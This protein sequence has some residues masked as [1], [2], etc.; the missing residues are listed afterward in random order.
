MNARNQTAWFAT[1]AALAIAL[2]IGFYALAFGVASVLF[3]IPYAEWRYL[4]RIDIRLA[5]G[6]IASGIALLVSVVPRKDHFVPPGPRLEERDHPKLFAVLRDVASATGQPMPLDVYLLNEVNAFVAARGGRMGIGSIRVMGVGLPLIQVLTVDGLRAVI[7]HEFGHFWAGDLKLGPWIH[8]THCAIAQTI[9]N[10]GDA[11]LGKPFV[12]YNQLFLR[13]TMAVSRRQEFV[14]DEISARVT[15]SN[16]AAAALQRIAVTAPA[17]TAYLQEEVVPALSSGVLPPLAS[18]FDQ[19]LSSPRIN[20]AMTRFAAEGIHWQG[21]AFDTHPAL[22]RRLEALAAVEMPHLRLQETAPASTLI[23]DPEQLATA[24]L[25]F[26]AGD[27]AVARLKPIG[28]SDVGEAVYAAGWRA[29]RQQFAAS[30]APFTI[31]SLPVGD[32]E[33]VEAGRRL[34]LPGKGRLVDRDDAYRRAI[35]VLVAA[36]GVYLMDRGWILQTSIGHPVLLVR[37]SEFIEPAAVV[38][39]LS[40]NTVDPA[41]WKARCTALGLAGCSLA[42][43][44][45]EHHTSV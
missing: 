8:K 31:D 21:H 34:V 33:T 6:C 18:G 4:E 15:S 25:S 23:N 16:V 43:E 35:E 9:A 3:W 27:E 38:V 28:W 22:D 44:A 11:W 10:L 14:A 39:G 24:L 40:Q 2:M 45:A 29:T 19:Y 42:P 12:W 36:L 17:Y 13:V 26:T 5:V 41:E 32:A 7:A 1:R 20:D 37:D 30:V